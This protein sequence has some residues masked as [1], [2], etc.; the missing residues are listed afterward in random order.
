[1]VT[2]LRPSIV[3]LGSFPSFRSGPPSTGISA[4]RVQVGSRPYVSRV[5]FES[6]AYEFSPFLIIFFLLSKP[7]TSSAG[8]DCGCDS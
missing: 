5:H 4:S 1:M 7:A 3:A 8:S 6:E 2:S